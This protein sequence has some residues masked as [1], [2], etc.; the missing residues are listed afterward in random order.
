MVAGLVVLAGCRTERKTDQAT[1]TTADSASSIGAPAGKRVPPPEVPPLTL[2]DLRIEAV[3]WGK[4]RGFDHN[5][6]YIAAFDRAGKELW[7]L[8]VYDIEYDAA[9]ES[10]VQ[11]VFIALIVQGASLDQIEV[12]DERGRRFAVDMRTK[13]VRRL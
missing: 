11:D 6:G 2:G 5:G 9:L 1:A 8:E 3:H 12:T 4:E 10:D 7:T 13:T